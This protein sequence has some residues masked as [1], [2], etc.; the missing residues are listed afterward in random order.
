[1]YLELAENDPYE[2]MGFM[3]SPRMAAPP[4]VGGQARSFPPITVGTP[5]VARAAAAAPADAYVYIPA[6][7]IGTGEG[8]YAREDSFDLLPNFQWEQLMDILEPYQQQNM[9][10][11][12]LGKKGRERRRLR[13]EARWAAKESRIEVRAES[14]GGALGR[15]ADAIKNIFG[16]GGVQA[17][18]YIA[19][20][21]GIDPET[22][23]PYVAP[24]K[25]I[26]GM[27][28]NTVIAVGGVGALI[29]VLAVMGGKKRRK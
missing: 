21:E 17:G 20:V 15:V 29:L 11:F 24:P 23:L 22:G 13:R 25:K 16:G 14:G 7:F 12:G 9:S 19:P 10:L 6:H 18:A 4:R 26:F 27:P 2:M 8:V 1:M 3:P 5:S 28:Q